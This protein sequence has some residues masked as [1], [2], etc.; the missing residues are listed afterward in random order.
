[1]TPAL[2]LRMPAQPPSTDTMITP[3]SLPAR[4]SAV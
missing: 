2:T 3:F 1:M 4:L